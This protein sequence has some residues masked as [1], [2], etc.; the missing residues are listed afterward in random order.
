M[1]TITSVIFPCHHNK[2]VP[3]N[4]MHLQEHNSD[5]DKISI[6]Q[7]ELRNSQAEKNALQRE[8]TLMAQGGGAHRHESGHRDEVPE[9]SEANRTLTK[10]VYEQQMKACV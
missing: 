2:D 4:D 10:Q 8:L 1:T 7:S 6:L 5:K 9:L 3:E